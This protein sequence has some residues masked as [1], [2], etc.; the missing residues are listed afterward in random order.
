MAEPIPKLT[1]R[2]LLDLLQ[3]LPEDALDKE[4]KVFLHT[5]GG[6]E[7][8]GTLRDIFRWDHDADEDDDETNILDVLWDLPDDVELRDDV[9]LTAW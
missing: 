6:A 7:F 5:E 9:I 4:A 3:K 2:G 1:Y 8:W